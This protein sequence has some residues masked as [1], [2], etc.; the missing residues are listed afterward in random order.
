MVVVLPAELIPAVLV[1]AGLLTET[2]EQV[3]LVI[4]VQDRLAVLLLQH[5]HFHLHQRHLYQN[6][7]QTKQPLITNRRILTLALRASSTLGTGA[8]LR[9]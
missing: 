2:P 7:S 4:P 5:H 6:L 1:L 8:G 3:L 9:F